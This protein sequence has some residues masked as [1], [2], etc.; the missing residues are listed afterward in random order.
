MK[1]KQHKQ[2]LAHHALVWG[3]STSVA[4]LL[5]VASL[6]PPIQAAQRPIEDFLTTQGSYGWYGMT[7]TDPFGTDGATWAEIDYAGIKGAIM[8]YYGYPPLGTTFSGK[9]T[10]RPLPDGRAEVQ[11]LLH[12]K[13]A[14]AWAAYQDLEDWTQPAEYLFGHDFVEVFFGAPLV[15]GDSTLQLKFINTAPNAP[16][17]DFWELVLGPQGGQ[18]LLS[19]YFIG[20]ADGPMADGSRGRMQITQVG[21]LSVSPPKPPLFDAY[22]VEHILLKA[23]GK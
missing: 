19:V 11:V 3:C 14:L 18:E 23:V 16:L 1:R 8:E 15:L 4:V 20:Q 17:P 2:N 7:W 21:L 10:E 9:V 12:T 6:A 13:N 22:P 5:F